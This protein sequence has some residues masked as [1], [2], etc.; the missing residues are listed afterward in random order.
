M[1]T[2]GVTG[3][4]DNKG[5]SA[6]YAEAASLDPSKRDP[7]FKVTRAVDAYDKYISKGSIDPDLARLMKDEIAFQKQ[8][9]ARKGYKTW[10]KTRLASQ[11]TS[12]EAFTHDQAGLLPCTNGTCAFIN[13]DASN[14]SKAVGEC[15][16]Q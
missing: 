16:Q 7:D 3:I 6:A 8:E 5:V 2:N 4:N 10:L 12:F 15:N 9:A 1:P 13:A 14:G 11:P